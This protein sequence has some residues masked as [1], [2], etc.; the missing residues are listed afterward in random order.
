MPLAAEYDFGL[1]NETAGDRAQAFDA[2][3]ANPDDG[4]PAL[5]WAR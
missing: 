1:G 3:L 2:V 5:P 4:Q